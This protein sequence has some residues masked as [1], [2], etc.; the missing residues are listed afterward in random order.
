MK[1]PDRNRRREMPWGNI[2]RGEWPG[3]G[4]VIV[5]KDKG[6]TSHD[7]VG[8]VRRL[9][10]TRKVGHAGTLDPM[11]TGVLCVAV[12][13]ATKLLQ[14]ITATVKEYE[15]TIRLGVETSTEDREGEI[16]STPGAGPVSRELLLEAMEKLTGQI[17]QVPSA[18][19][20]IKVGGKRAYQ[21]VREGKDVQ[22]AARRVT[23]Y[24]FSLIGEHRLEHYDGVSVIDCDVR[25]LCSSGTYI[26]ALARDLGKAL[27]TVAHLTALRRTRVGNWSQED[28]QTIRSLAD[29]LE[30]R[31]ATENEAKQGNGVKLVSETNKRCGDAAHGDDKPLRRGD[32]SV[33]F[34]YNDAMIQVGKDEEMSQASKD[35]G[36]NITSSKLTPG[37]DCAADNDGPMI[38]DNDVPIGEVRGAKLP[39]ISLAQLCRSLFPGVL[40]DD[41]EAKDLM[42]GRFIADR[43]WNVHLC[44]DTGLRGKSSVSSGLSFSRDECASVTQK[45]ESIGEAQKNECVS[46]AEDKD[47]GV[48]PEQRFFSDVTFGLEREEKEARNDKDVCVAKV[49]EE[50]GKK[51]DI[52]VAWCNS[53]PIALVSKRHGK[54]KPDLLLATVF[55]CQ[56]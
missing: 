15:A 22:L 48:D 1:T 9:A 45:D 46:G 49:N 38:A 32:K 53:T 55:S 41:S 35:K 13:R 40:V 7:V 43:P 36:Q 28:A 27:G 51:A 20:A 31:L 47:S 42:Q 8:A 5:D 44:A 19:S 4:I 14:Y 12:G 16:L 21:L 26:R 2:P 50:N 52:A 30:T 6:V 17:D 11:A 56:E 25:V 54:L 24:E 3:D 23:I 29:V 37:A 10:G 34:D 18:V 39:L 33:I